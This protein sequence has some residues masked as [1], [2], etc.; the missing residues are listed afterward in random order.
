MTESEIICI[1]NKMIF[2][3]KKSK[4]QVFWLEV[5][6]VWTL[7]CIFQGLVSIIYLIRSLLVSL[8]SCSRELEEEKMGAKV[9]TESQ[10]VYFQHPRDITNLS[11]HGLTLEMAAFNIADQVKT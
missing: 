6:D 3:G 10:A 9:Q 2:I 4:K 7:Q 5:S 11:A 1:G 8:T